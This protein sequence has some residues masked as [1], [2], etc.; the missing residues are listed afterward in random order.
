MFNSYRKHL[1]DQKLKGTFQAKCVSTDS[2]LRI[3]AGPFSHRFRVVE[4][5]WA[6]PEVMD[7]AA[8]SLAALSMSS[9]VK[10]VFDAPVSRDAAQ[11][12]EALTNIYRFWAIRGL[13]PLRLD[14]PE[15][16]A[17]TFESARSHG[18]VMC[19]SGGIDS[20]YAAVSE[21]Q[22][23]QLTHGLLIAG[24]DYR[25][26]KAQGFQE[27]RCRVDYVAD[28]L[29]LNVSVIETDIRQLRFNWG[30]MHGFVLAASLHVME[31]TH[32]AGRIALDYA[33][34]QEVF[35]HPWG[36]SSV[37]PQYFSTSHFPIEGVGREKRR[38]DKLARIAEFD[39]DL[40]NMLSICFSDTETG[41]N[42]GKCFKCT[43]TR[44]LF[45]ALDLD[46]AAAFQATPSLEDAV[47]HLT[48]PKT[49]TALRSRYLRISETLDALPKGSL[50][51][52]LSS[53]E[54]ALRRAYIIKSIRR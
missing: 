5:E 44:M 38:I 10:F 41:G 15:Q 18:C 45:H 1:Q 9:G 16:S 13:G 23:G 40:P 49:F 4:G 12:I 37:L 25:D 14:L 29:G 50:R 20:V 35:N 30:M 17:S 33:G 2:E 43:S 11:R 52:K 26:A 21:H 19:L 27:L 32:P 8:Y 34:Y 53:Y 47:D 46:Q 42:C 51:D 22:N 36:N 48:V 31:R 7:F 39:P 3:E 6:L 54:Q 28:R 24:A